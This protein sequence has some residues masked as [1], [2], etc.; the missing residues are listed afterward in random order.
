MRNEDEPLDDDDYELV[1]AEEVDDNLIYLNRAQDYGHEVNEL[2]EAT[3]SYREESAN[4][5]SNLPDKSDHKRPK[6]KPAAKS[7]Y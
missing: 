7:I 2:D 3:L 1:M 4:V 6:A 5:S